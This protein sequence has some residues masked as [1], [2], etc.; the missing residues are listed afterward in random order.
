MGE[1]GHARSSGRER[2]RRTASLS[3]LHI[4]DSCLMFWILSCAFV[5]CIRM[6]HSPQRHAR[7]EAHTQPYHAL[8]W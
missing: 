3:R 2:R 4:H 1:R 6:Q 5:N 7:L 8:M